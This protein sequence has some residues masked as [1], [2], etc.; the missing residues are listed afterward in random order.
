MHPCGLSLRLVEPGAPH[1][2]GRDHPWAVGQHHRKNTRQSTTDEEPVWRPRPS[3]RGHDHDPGATDEGK[4]LGV[5][6]ARLPPTRDR[7]AAEANLGQSLK[8]DVTFI[9]TETISQEEQMW[10]V[11]PGKSRPPSTKFTPPLFSAKTE[12]KGPNLRLQSREG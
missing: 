6:T 2:L 4:H 3:T 7:E 5:P 11:G 12:A 1:L 10:G 9:V 8:S